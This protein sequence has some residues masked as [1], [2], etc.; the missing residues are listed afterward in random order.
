MTAVESRN[1][2]KAKIS[3]GETRWVKPSKVVLRAKRNMLLTVI[4]VEIQS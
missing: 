1:L 2:V 3:S 4:V